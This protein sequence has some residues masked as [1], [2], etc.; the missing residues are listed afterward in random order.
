V[1]EIDGV[2]VH[3]EPSFALLAVALI[4]ELGALLRSAGAELRRAAFTL[5]APGWLRQPKLVERRLVE[6]IGIDRKHDYQ[7]V[8]KVSCSLVV[9]IKPGFDLPSHQTY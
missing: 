8:M 6:L 7:W 5:L 2:S 9:G 4:R 1:P 3:W